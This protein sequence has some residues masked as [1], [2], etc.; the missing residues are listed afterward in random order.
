MSSLL[1]TQLE[2]VER[3]FSSLR[4]LEMQANISARVD[5]DM[6]EHFYKPSLLLGLLVLF[7]SRAFYLLVRTYL[8]YRV[9]S[10][11]AFQR[12]VQ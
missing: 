9:R 2:F 11:L 3:W 7:A 4:F 1:E 10:M 8:E 6:S 5:S 12:E